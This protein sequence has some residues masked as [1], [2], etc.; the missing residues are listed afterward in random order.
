[1]FNHIRLGHAYSRSDL[2]DEWGYSGYQAIARG[3]VTPKD[4]NKIILF[5]TLQKQAAL[6]QYDDRFDGATLK[7]E[8]PN[9]HFAEDRMVA[10]ARGNDEIHLFCRKVHHTDFTYCG[11]LKA[12]NIERLTNRP[13]RFAFKLVDGPVK[14]I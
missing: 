3:V 4:S 1:M 5:V 2:A 13:S 10:A 8:G 6:E 9:D 7:W 12:T 14:L 11:Q